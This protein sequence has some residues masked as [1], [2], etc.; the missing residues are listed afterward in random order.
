MGT[1]RMRANLGNEDL[2]KL[3]AP[4]GFMSLTSFLLKKVENSEESCNSV[5]FASASAQEP[6]C[7]NAPSDMVDAGTS[8]RSPRNRPW[9][10]YEQSDNN[11][12]ESNFE[13]PVEVIFLLLRCFVCVF[14]SVF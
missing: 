10:L 1:K 7:T 12:K 14:V 2:D 13:Q 3:S 5:A 6:V 11:Q 9:I 4:P 8:K